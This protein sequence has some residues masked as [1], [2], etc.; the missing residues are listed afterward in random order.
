M[1]EYVFPVQAV[2]PVL[3]TLGPVPAEHA[4][5]VALKLSTTFGATHSWH[6][7]PKLE[8]VDPAQATQDARSP[9]GWVPAG[10][11]SQADCKSFALLPRSVHAVQLSPG[12]LD[13]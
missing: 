11:L 13:T 8:Y 12:L 6:S 4:V 5:H 2:H 7:M 3:A 1:V 9:A 10:Q